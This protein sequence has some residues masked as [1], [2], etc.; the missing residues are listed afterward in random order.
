MEHI[1]S[2]KLETSRCVACVWVLP[3]SP[4]GWT[5][6]PTRCFEYPEPTLVMTVYYPRM[7]LLCHSPKQIRFRLIGITRKELGCR[8]GSESDRW[9]VDCYHAPSPLMSPLR[10]SVVDHV[11]LAVPR[12]PRPS[13]QIK[14]F[15]NIAAINPWII[16]IQST[17]SQIRISLKSKL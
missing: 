14:P 3:P 16:W 1:Y 13:R 9:N 6:G 17:Y 4:E 15:A 8:T 5:L 7:A 10:N 12:R 2:C 11:F